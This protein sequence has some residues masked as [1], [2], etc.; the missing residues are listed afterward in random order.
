M[1]SLFIFQAVSLFSSM[2][3]RQAVIAIWVGAP[4]ILLQ[5]GNFDTPI[6]K[7][8]YQFRKAANLSNR[9][10]AFSFNMVLPC[11]HTLVMM[12]FFSISENCRTVETY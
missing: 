3:V 8:N 10:H 7:N 6:M 5:N 9:A 1:L 2:N 11:C 12:P 4:N